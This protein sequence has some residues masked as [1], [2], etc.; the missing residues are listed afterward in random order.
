MSESILPEDDDSDDVV[1]STDLI[2]VEVKK[3]DVTP[4]AVF[5]PVAV[6]IPAVKADVC[7]L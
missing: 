7:T 6:I 2:P 1:S 5:N 3:L 4:C